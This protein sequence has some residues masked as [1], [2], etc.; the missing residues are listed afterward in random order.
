MTIQ[1]QLH[2]LSWESIE[3]GPHLRDRNRVWRIIDNK[4]IN[5]HKDGKWL[6]QQGHKIVACDDALEVSCRYNCNQSPF[7]HHQCLATPFDAAPMCRSR[8]NQPSNTVLLL[9]SIQLRLESLIVLNNM[10]MSSLHEATNSS[11]SSKDSQSDTWAVVHF[12]LYLFLLLQRYLWQTNWVH[13]KCNLGCIQM[14]AFWR[15]VPT[16]FC[17]WTCYLLPYPKMLLCNEMSSHARCQMQ[18]I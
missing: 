9:L 3:V 8:A 16:Y 5:G 6:L 12:C 10:K 17:W 14:G 2:K 13:E 7:W 1:V 15:A 11:R 4:G 18:S